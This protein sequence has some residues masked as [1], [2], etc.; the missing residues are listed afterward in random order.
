MF[1]YLCSCEKSR[2][3]LG[4]EKHV[5]T[6]VNARACAAGNRAPVDLWLHRRRHKEKRDGDPTCE[7]WMWARKD[8][9]NLSLVFEHDGAQ[10]WWTLSF[11]FADIQEKPE[12]VLQK[13]LSQP[14]RSR[15]KHLFPNW[16]ILAT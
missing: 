4:G 1:V 2:R 14:W 12:T 13:S 6:R 5:L 9:R 16:V 15:E 10:S 7:I 8:P 11:D 3:K